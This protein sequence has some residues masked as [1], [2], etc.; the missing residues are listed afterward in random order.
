MNTSPQSKTTR[1]WLIVLALASLLLGL[2]PTVRSLLLAL[3]LRLGN[4]HWKARSLR[5]LKAQGPSALPIMAMAFS[6]SDPELREQLVLE[7]GAMGPEAYSALAYALQDK[8]PSITRAAATL[9]ASSGRRGAER[10]VEQVFEAD[11]TPVADIDTRCSSLD[12]YPSVLASQ[13]L[14]QIGSPSLEPLRQGLR[15][16]NPACQ[17]WAAATL[18]DFKEQARFAAWDLAALLER[19]AEPASPQVERALLNLKLAPEDFATLLRPYFQKTR[20]QPGS[21]GLAIRLGRL[22]RDNQ[23]GSVGLADELLAVML[24]GPEKAQVM[25]YEALI[26]LGPKARDLVQGL[27]SGLESKAWINRKRCAK[28]LSYLGRHARSARPALKAAIQRESDRV[29]RIELESCLAYID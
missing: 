22:A 14:L 13:V 17:Y 28:I 2:S 16:D 15:S 24:S 20:S 6:D 10:L 29:Q 1:R 11:T 7:L 25:A 18:K 26:A 3:P 21:S 5:W 19:C 4:K 8:D 12:D 27:S 23:Q 9:L